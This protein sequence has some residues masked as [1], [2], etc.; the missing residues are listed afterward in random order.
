MVTTQTIDRNGHHGLSKKARRLLAAHD[1]E[2]S[3]RQLREAL[4]DAA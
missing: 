1:R 3:E 4:R 2:V